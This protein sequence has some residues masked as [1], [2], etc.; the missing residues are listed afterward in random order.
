MLLTAFL[1]VVTASKLRFEH[2][3]GNPAVASV[4]Y[5]EQAKTYSIRPALD[6]DAIAFAQYSDTLNLTGWGV[7]D[8]TGS[9]QKG[10]FS[11]QQVY[12]AHGLLEGHMTAERISQNAQTMNAYW[13]LG[14][15]QAKINDFFIAQMEWA[16]AQVAKNKD[17]P[18]WQNI[19][20]VLYQLNGLMDGAMGVMP[21]LTKWDLMM[22]N[23]VGDL[24]DLTRALFPK[25]RPDI[26]HLNQTELDNVKHESGH[27]SA[28]VRVTPGFED[29]FMGHSSWFYYGA[30][31]RIYKKY[32]FDVNKDI[33]K[34]SFS[35]YAGYLESLD[36]F[37]I[38]NTGLVMLQTT[39]NCL[40]STLYDYVTPNSL[41]AWQ[42]VR[43][44][45]RMAKTGPEWAL[46][47]MRHNSGTYNNQYMVIDTKLFQK[48]LPLNDNL[49]TVI[50]QMPN[51]VASGDQTDFL[52][53]G[54]YWPSYNV[55]FFKS[56]YDVSGNAAAAAKDPINS[57]ELCPRAKIFRRDAAAVNEFSQFQ[58]ILR[59]NDF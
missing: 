36:D 31:N 2:D 14:D 24:I 18:F 45:N 39:I 52:R 21:H 5:D 3:V 20:Y 46:Y 42:R 32:T 55:P 53:M 26:N 7:L 40:N 11:P 51:N 17:D 54:G 35:S 58:D 19:G 43:V 37:Y 33:F 16:E 27:C 29:L 23:G 28:L 4:I 30:T 10:H 41:L 12:Y 22:L 8:I 50:E 44:A 38:M 9:D 1:S 57:Y 34:M 48:G 15:K 59:Y 13:N 49:L 56:I 47:S 25:D 6:T